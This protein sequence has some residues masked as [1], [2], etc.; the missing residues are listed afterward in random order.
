MAAQL[1]FFLIFLLPPVLLNVPLL[2]AALLPVL[3][4]DFPPLPLH[5]LSAIIPLLLIVLLSSPLK[6]PQITS[7][8]GER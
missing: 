6:G 5:P 2:T 3:P 8:C 1:P 4:T 7:N